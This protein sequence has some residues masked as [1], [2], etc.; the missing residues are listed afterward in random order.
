MEVQTSKVNFRTKTII[1]ATGGA[2]WPGTGSAG[3]GYKI[4]AEMGHN[5]VKL[6][7]ALVP[8]IVQETDAAKAMQGVSLRNIRAT[9]FQGEAGRIDATLTPQIDYGRGRDKSPPAPL[10]ESRFGEMLFT[11]FGLG[12]PV[13]LRTFATMPPHVKGMRIC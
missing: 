9:A 11:H 6:K 1:V 13:I 7:P 10:I 8:L 2:T 3:D 5:I 12:G 4:S